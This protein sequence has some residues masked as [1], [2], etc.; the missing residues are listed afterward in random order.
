MNPFV[1]FDESGNTGQ[2]L[3]NHNQ[4]MFS[5]APVYLSDAKT[6]ETINILTTQT[7]QEIEYI[8]RG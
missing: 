1:A 6:E 2:D 5:L 7:D 4:P 3:L 8:A